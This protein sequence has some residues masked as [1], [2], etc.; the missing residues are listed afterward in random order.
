VYVSQPDNSGNNGYIYD[1]SNGTTPY[2]PSDD[3]LNKCDSQLQVNGA[4]VSNKVFMDRAF[5]SMRYGSPGESITNT[6]KGCGASDST[7]SGDCS[8][9]LFNFS[10]ELYLQQPAMSEIN[11][12]NSGEYDY[13]TSL[14]PV[15]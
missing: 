2:T 9:E 11:G 14:S 12:P 15:L 7:G 5:S 1:C 8:A 3:L 10:P 4:F 6:F 13:I